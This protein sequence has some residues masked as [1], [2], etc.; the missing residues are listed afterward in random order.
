MQQTYLVL[1][2]TNLDLTQSF[3][4]EHQ[5]ITSCLLN[6]AVK[7]NILIYDIDIEEGE[8]VREHARR[9]VEMHEK[10]INLLRYNNHICSVNDI[11]TIFKPLR[12]PV[13]INLQSMQVILTVN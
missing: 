4:E 8:F 1:F 6:I 5:S 7:H 2:F 10:N 3:S 9:S 13:K 11:N 12:Y